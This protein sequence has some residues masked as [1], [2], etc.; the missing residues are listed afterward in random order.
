[1]SQPLL[2]QTN[3]TGQQFQRSGPPGQGQQPI[4]QQQPGSEKHP[5]SKMVRDGCCA[6]KPEK[7]KAKVNLTSQIIEGETTNKRPRA[8]LQSQLIGNLDEISTS[9]A[10]HHYGIQG[11]PETPR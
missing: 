4:S 2:T 10:L 9:Q 8:C 6:R 11:L 7:Q 3:T 1:M 5:A